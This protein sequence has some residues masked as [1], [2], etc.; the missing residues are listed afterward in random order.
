MKAYVPT[1]V[2]ALVML[3]AYLAQNK[4]VLTGDQVLGLFAALGLSGTALARPVR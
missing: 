4:G 3:S 2:S 1:I